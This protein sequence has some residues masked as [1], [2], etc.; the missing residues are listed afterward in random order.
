MIIVRTAIVLK[1]LTSLQESKP[2]FTVSF[3]EIK[4]ILRVKK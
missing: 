2:N 3:T 4:E 1:D